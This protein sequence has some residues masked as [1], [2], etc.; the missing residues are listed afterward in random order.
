MSNFG[1]F[2]MPPLQIWSYHV[3]QEANFKKFYFFLILHL[4]L[5]KAEK[6]VVEKLSTSDVISQ[7]PHGGGGGWKAFRVNRQ[8][9][10]LGVGCIL[11]IQTTSLIR[12]LPSDTEIIL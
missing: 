1:I 6:F 2:T 10:I 3:I 9:L 7:K 12:L 4:I 8:L 5:G 11:Y